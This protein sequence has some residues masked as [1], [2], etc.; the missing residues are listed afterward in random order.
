MEQDFSGLQKSIGYSFSDNEL[1]RRAFLH[2]SADAGE[3]YERL[4]FLGDAV[5]ELV[6]SEVLYS[7]KESSP[8]GELTKL[9]AA[10]V[11]E[12]SLV[13][14]A[15]DLGLGGYIVLGR[16]ERNTGGEDKPSILSDVLEA[17]IGAVY[18][19]GGLDQAKKLVLRLLDES[20]D[21]VLSGGGFKDYKT[22]LQEFYHKKGTS[23][24]KY[25]VYKEEGPPH[26]RVFYVKLCIDGEEKAEGKGS[27]KKNAEQ[28]AA[29]QAY[30]QVCQTADKNN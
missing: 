11:N 15:R 20:I 13:T 10:L 25:T 17:M 21:T 12:G 27:S 3:S 23:D 8:E 6:I 26:S 18:L 2:S 5:L 7:K 24:I 14:V 9:R 19:D 30:L 22:K 29:K 4:E 28:R 1:L 16:G